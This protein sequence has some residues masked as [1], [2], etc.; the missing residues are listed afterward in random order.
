MASQTDRLL[1]EKKVLTPLER[2]AAWRVVLFDYSEA[3]KAW[4]GSKSARR[5]ANLAMVE[6]AL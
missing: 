5:W 4:H 1:A 3:G 6:G 2:P